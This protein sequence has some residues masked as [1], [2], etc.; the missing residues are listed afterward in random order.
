MLVTYLKMR[1]FGCT[2]SSK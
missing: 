1:E 2:Y